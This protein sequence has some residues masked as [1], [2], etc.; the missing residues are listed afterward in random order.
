M[1]RQTQLLQI[2]DQ[3]KEFCLADRVNLRGLSERYGT[4]EFHVLA[5]SLTRK[6]QKIDG[7]ELLQ[8]V[9]FAIRRFAIACLISEIPISSDGIVEILSDALADNH[10]HKPVVHPIT[11]RAR[12]PLSDAEF[13]FRAQAMM[14]QIFNPVSKEF[15]GL[16]LKRPLHEARATYNRAT[17]ERQAKLLK[18]NS[19][20]K[21]ILLTDGGIK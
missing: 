15:S 2:N 14:E 3:I 19:K 11:N 5:D 13:S 7:K 18:Q 16:R 17:P 10:L 21:T 4:N 20:L 8:A 1:N 9:S 6:Y 12:S